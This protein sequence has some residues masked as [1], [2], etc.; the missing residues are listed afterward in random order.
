MFSRCEL[1]LFYNNNIDLTICHILNNVI[2]S[3]NCVVKRRRGCEEINR[4]LNRE[5]ATTVVFHVKCF[6]EFITL[7]DSNVTLPINIYVKQKPPTQSPAMVV[8]KKK[9]SIS[10]ISHYIYWVYLCL[11]Y[12]LCKYVANINILWLNNTVCETACICFVFI[13]IQNGWRSKLSIVNIYIPYH[14]MC[15]WKY[16]KTLVVY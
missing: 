7:L 3:C 9:T 5:H 8:I 11:F 16:D 6:S 13:S 14:K 2:I 4:V 1:H 12:A 10:F 15:L